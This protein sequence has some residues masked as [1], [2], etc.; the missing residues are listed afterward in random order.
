MRSHGPASRVAL[1]SI[2]ALGPCTP[3]VPNVP[4]HSD[5]FVIDSVTG[6]GNAGCSAIKGEPGI[7]LEDPPN[8][9]RPMQPAGGQWSTPKTPYVGK[10]FTGDYLCKPRHVFVSR[11]PR[12]MPDYEF[13]PGDAITLAVTL[14]FA[15][16]EKSPQYLFYWLPVTEV[17]QTKAEFPAV[18][19]AAAKGVYEMATINAP[20]EFGRWP[21][22]AGDAKLVRTGLTAARTC[23]VANQLL[24]C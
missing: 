19:V 12:V 9:N 22:K 18:I 10:I 2:V 23:M 7:G 20:V 11:N 1:A 16:D 24:T 4:I 8:G 21:A 6:D 3:A 15:G 17:G 13:K 5:A 14:P